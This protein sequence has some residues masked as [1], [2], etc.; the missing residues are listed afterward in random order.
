MWKQV[1]FLRSKCSLIITWYLSIC[2]RLLGW[3]SLAILISL[4]EEFEYKN[5]AK[6]ANKLMR[7]VGILLDTYV[8]S[9]KHCAWNQAFMVN[10]RMWIQ[11]KDQLSSPQIGD[12]NANLQ[13]I[14]NDVRELFS[15]NSSIERDIE[16]VRWD[17]QMILW[18]RSGAHILER[19]KLK[20][21]L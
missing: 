20:L 18:Y 10:H 14:C 15:L 13:C 1:F 7:V 4:N 5:C 11:T 12:F 16:L 19:F 8:P 17:K 21:E 2:L 6:N 3:F 9:W